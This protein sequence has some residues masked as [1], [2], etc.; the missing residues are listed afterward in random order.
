MKLGSAIVI[1]ALFLIIASTTISGSV[2]A[3]DMTKDVIIMDESG[4][5]EVRGGTLLIRSDEF[6]VAK[7]NRSVYYINYSGVRS[8]LSG[9]KIFPMIEG[10]DLTIT[11]QV[12]GEVVLEATVYRYTLRRY[13]ETGGEGSLATNVFIGVMWGSFN[14]FGVMFYAY[15]KRVKVIL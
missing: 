15:K 12:S 4:E 14:G 1:N 13:L 3:I 10:A 6:I 11:D 7:V 2:R 5:I 8:R 9:F